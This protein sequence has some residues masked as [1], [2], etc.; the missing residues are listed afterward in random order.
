MVNPELRCRTECLDQGFVYCTNINFISF[1][2]ADKTK[3]GK[4]CS[5]ANCQSSEDFVCTTALENAPNE[6]KYLTCPNE[7]EECGS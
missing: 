4:C 5:E 2:G 1:E 7:V 3:N 6:F